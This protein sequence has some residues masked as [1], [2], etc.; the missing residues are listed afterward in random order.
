MLGKVRITNAEEQGTTAVSNAFIDEFMAD[1]NDAQIKIYLYLLRALQ[2]GRA[3]TV[4]E[5]ADLFN[6]TERDVKRALQYWEKKG[7]V[8]LEYDSQKRL[9]QICLEDLSASADSSSAIA[10]Q[11]TA[12][13][14]V[15]AQPPAVVKPAVIASYPGTPFIQ[16]K[17]PSAASSIEQDQEL[18]MICFAAE[19]YFKKTLSP[20]ETSAILYVRQQ[21]GFSTDLIDYLL[22]Y[23]AENA[24]GSW[25][26]YFQ[27]TAVSWH[28][29]GICTLAAAKSRAGRYDNTV[30]T[31]MKLLGLSNAPTVFEADYFN[32]WIK[33]YGFSMELIKEACRRT[34]SNTQTKRV[35][36]TDG[37]LA[38][39]KKNGVTNQADIAQLDAAHDK[40]LTSKRSS[41]TTSP[42][43]KSQFG[44]HKQQSYDFDTIKRLKA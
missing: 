31:I 27:K 8:R 18:P 11:T 39:W 36:Y 29:E 2:S 35:E 10:T 4:P 21:L 1:A 20:N 23:T 15:S 3:T 28:E 37:I 6:H 38:N 9:S 25:S 22:Q 7:L 5:I 24:K 32:K 44:S 14:T 17:A 16:D 41:K 43:P 30:Y 34:V 33:E 19:K 40:E 13:T 26:A 12:L 42:A